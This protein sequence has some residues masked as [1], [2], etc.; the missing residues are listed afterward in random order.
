MDAPIDIRNYDKYIFAF[1]GGK[2]SVKAV[3]EALKRGVD[4]AKCELWHHE[5]DGREGSRLMDWPCTPAYCRAFADAF[6]IPLFY[7]WR[8]G[9][10]EREML[11][12][13]DRTA[14]VVFEQPDGTLGMAG[15]EHGPEGTRLR[16]PQMSANLSV[17]W[18]SAALK[19]DVGAAALRNQDRFLGLR[20][21]FI[22]G[23]RGEESAC[24]ANYKHSE[25]H[26]TDNRD[27]KRKARHVDHWRMIQHA[28][29]AEVW[30]TIAEYCVNPHPAY[31]LGWGRVS[32][33]GCIFGN[34]NQWA[35]LRRVN[36]AQFDQLAEYEELFGVTIRRKGT[37]I[38]AAARGMPYA[39]ITQER[40]DAA[41]STEYHQPIILPASEW[42]LPPGAFGE[43][44]GP[45]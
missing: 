1:S 8:V 13:G 12:E 6:Q 21:L 37:I 15:G 7:S 20:T 39:A 44:N 23:E 43:S 14:P 4:P 40:I 45:T 11:R 28:T 35:S 42:R 19:I 9:G 10:F 32:C 31:W 16:F 22:S 29:E 18:C 30:A 25:P 3:L 26:R 34:P 2:D 5:I 36:P 27:G 24:R 17:R 33:A 41:L 38:E